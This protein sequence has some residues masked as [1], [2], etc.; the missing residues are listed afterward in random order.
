V[1]A[2]ITLRGLD[3]F[4]G[5]LGELENSLPKALSVALAG[6]SD[7]VLTDARRRVPARTGNARASLA[8]RVL[9]GSAGSTATV[10]GGGSRAP[11]FPWLDFGGAVGRR[12][13]VRRPYLGTGR[14]V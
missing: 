2:S 11:Y 10:V 9:E 3:E 13:S 5:A 4:R 8:V 1:N 7:L 6:C 14:Y 12:H